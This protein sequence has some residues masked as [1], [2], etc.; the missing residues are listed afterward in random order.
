MAKLI[1]LDKVLEILNDAIQESDDFAQDVIY[2]E[3][4]KA[5][6]EKLPTTE[7]GWI[8]VSERLPRVYTD[9]LC[10][11]KKRDTFFVWHLWL[12]L[13]ENNYCWNCWDDIWVEVELLIPLP[14][15]LS[16]PEAPIK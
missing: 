11:N 4:A 7:T 16:L 8:S 5:D 10:A 14:N 3:G 9:V 12:D 13:E 6:I 2:L 1:E 15:E